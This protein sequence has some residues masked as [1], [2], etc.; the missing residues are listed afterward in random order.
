MYNISMSLQLSREKIGGGVK[1]ELPTG[2]SLLAARHLICM[3][4]QN[5]VFLRSL[6][7][8]QRF[9]KKGNPSEVLKV[10]ILETS[11]E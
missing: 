2:L 4:R 7:I 9:P 3:S 1:E 5:K 11:Q 6:S 10:N 8:S